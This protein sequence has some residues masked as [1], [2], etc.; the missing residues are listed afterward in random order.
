VIVQPSEESIARA[1]EILREGGLVAFPTETV[2][3]LGA[4]AFSDDAT[5][6]IFKAKGRPSFNPLIVHIASVDEIP[7]V[8]AL[9]NSTMVER[10]IKL[11]AT[12]WPGPLSI[13]LPKA[14]AISSVVTA[15]LST[16]AVRIPDHPIALRLLKA[17]GLPIAAPSANPFS[18]ISPTTAQ[19]VEEGLSDHPPFIL[20][21]GPCRVGLE[22]T[23]VTILEP[24]VRILRPGGITR[25]Q[26][27]ALLGEQEVEGLQSKPRGG[28]KSASEGVTSPQPLAPGMLEQHYA[29][30]TPL[31]FRSDLPQ[32][33]LPKKVGLLSFREPPVGEPG[34]VFSSVYVLSSEG[35]LEEAA[36]NLFSA[37]RV[38][39]RQDLDL[40]LV[41]S[42][43]DA[44]LGLAIM[45]RLRRAC[46]S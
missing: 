41:D 2:Y 37:L 44:G 39:D 1:A 24:K 45:D 42:C 11:L 19:H 8:A 21:G 14:T 29:P 27:T 15:G 22:S 20:D 35:D 30:R 28:T 17:C 3:G 32:G 12:L 38:L 23:I 9:P 13:I 46:H 40:I 7:L 31:A 36:A 34:N 43:P 18:G 25:E 16:V 6:G 26:L 5:R 10:R 33:A 4:N